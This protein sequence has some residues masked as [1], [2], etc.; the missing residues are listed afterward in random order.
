[1]K[2]SKPIEWPQMNLEQLELFLTTS[3]IDFESVDDSSLVVT[4]SGVNR[5]NISFVISLQQYSMQAEAFVARRPE[6]NREQV[7][8]WLLEQNQKLRLTKFTLDRLGDIYLAASLPITALTAEILDAV[9]G[10]L[11]ATTDHS[12]NAILKM[13]FSTAIERE[14]VWRTSRGLDT[15]NL[16]ALR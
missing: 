1:M 16:D 13:G 14:Y 12:F 10:E 7:F 9:I 5:K 6:D 8:E 3:G 15:T 4:V 2:L 11:V